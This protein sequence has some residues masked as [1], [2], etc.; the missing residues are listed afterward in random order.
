MKEIRDFSKCKKSYKYFGGSERKI[1]LMIDGNPYMVK[2]QNETE[3]GKR[4]NHISEFL[5]SHNFEM[6]GFETQ[7]T[8]LGK[9][10]D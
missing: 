10:H 2:F 8:I 1:G 9:Y 6:L 3:F 4:N 7:E 5:G